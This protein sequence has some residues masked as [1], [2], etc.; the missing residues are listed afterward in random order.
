MTD[1]TWSC[2]VHNFEYHFLNNNI[3]NGTFLDGTRVQ[4]QRR[5]ALG[6]FLGVRRRVNNLF[7][8]ILVRTG[9]GEPHSTVTWAMYS[10]IASS[11]PLG[12]DALT[13]DADMVGPRGMIT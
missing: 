6:Q 1:S 3:Q 12:S 10:M 4:Q 9:H 13:L 7:V 8:H 5:D 11:I 2:F